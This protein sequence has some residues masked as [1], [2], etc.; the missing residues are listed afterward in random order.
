MQINSTIDRWDY[1]SP[2]NHAADIF[3]CGS[4]LAIGWIWGL[5]Q[6]KRLKR[7]FPAVLPYQ[8]SWF[9]TFLGC[10]LIAW[11]ALQTYVKYL[12]SW[13]DVLWMLSPCHVT[14]VFWIITLFAKNRYTASW[15][16]NIAFAYTFYTLMAL[17]FPDISE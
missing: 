13:P 6:E 3:I 16:Y 12:R 10:L 2:V 9:D 4:F 1:L 5:Y 17:A 8:N 7:T 14:T 15:A 11:L